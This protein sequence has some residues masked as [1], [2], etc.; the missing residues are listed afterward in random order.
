M[1]V[2]AKSE[3]LLQYALVIR[4]CL[5]PRISRRWRLQNEVMSCVRLDSPG[6]GE[7]PVCRVLDIFVL[8]AKAVLAHSRIVSKL[9]SSQSCPTDEA[10]PVSVDV[11]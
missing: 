3:A 11:M 4:V 1:A 9:E 5:K 10:V 2:A 8:Q 7:L 6:A